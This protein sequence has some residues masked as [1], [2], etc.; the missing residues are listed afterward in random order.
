M[1]P[2]NAP[3]SAGD[4]HLPCVLSAGKLVADR[5]GGLAAEMGDFLG[6]E[7]SAVRCLDVIGSHGRASGP[8]AHAPAWA[9]ARHTHPRV[10]LGHLISVIPAKVGDRGS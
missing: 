6:G 5:V 2:A 8:R 9:L 1:T 3:G 7:Q 10:G 4:P